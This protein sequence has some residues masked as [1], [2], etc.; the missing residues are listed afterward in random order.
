VNE[1]VRNNVHSTVNIGE[2][3]PAVG[4][5]IRK[6]G[7]KIRKNPNE[8]QNILIFKGIIAEKGDTS[9]ERR[10]YFGRKNCAEFLPP[11]SSTDSD[12]RRILKLCFECGGVRMK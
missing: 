2:S 1:Q 8:E 11:K 6:K 7:A 12:R 3:K 4:E 9:R 10:C 5:G